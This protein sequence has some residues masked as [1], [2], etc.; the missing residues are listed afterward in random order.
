MRYDRFVVLGAGAGGALNRSIERFTVWVTPHAAGM[1]TISQ[2]MISTTGEVRRGMT[3]G[4]S[5]DIRHLRF[6]GRGCYW[7]HGPDITRK[8]P[9]VHRADEQV[10]DEADHEQPGHHVQDE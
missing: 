7:R 8:V 6:A 5:P 9:L 1:P 2:A 4:A 3:L 10:R